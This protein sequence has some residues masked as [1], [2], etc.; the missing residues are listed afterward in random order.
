M[1][2]KIT[3]TDAPATTTT[4]VEAVNLRG[5]T[6]ALPAGALHRMLR[7]VLPA[8][9]RDKAR[10]NIAQ[11]LV[12]VGAH[13]P[14]GSFRLVATDGY[15]LH[16]VEAS[17]VPVAHPRP[18][19]RLAWGWSPAEAERLAKAVSGKANAEAVAFVGPSEVR[20]EGLPGDLVAEARIMLAPTTNAA[21]FPPYR[22]CMVPRGGDPR[23]SSEGA[24]TRVYGVCPKYM[25]EALGAVDALDTA[26]DTAH[27]QSSG[28]E[29][30]PV[31]VYGTASAGP[32]VL[33]V[34][35]VV[36]P[37]RI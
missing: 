33:E 32:V 3:I 12:E 35:V 27:V 2:S 15:R 5:A 36:M 10:P 7:A 26:H 8:A 1:P 21:D 18:G 30:D 23:G 37:K 14:S 28:H 19:E 13:G 17:N 4:T 31:L 11:V 34:D 24:G 20:V 29:L 25:I 9:S 6:F 22:T 16:V